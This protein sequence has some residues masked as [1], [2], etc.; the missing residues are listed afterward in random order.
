MADLMEIARGMGCDRVLLIT[1][2]RGSPGKLEM[3]EIDGGGFEAIPPLI[4]LKGI[5]LRREFGVEGRFI[6]SAIT[7]GPVKREGV[8]LARSLSSFLR[9]PMIEDRGAPRVAASLHIS[10]DRT[11]SL[12][13]AVT[14]P[15]KAKEVGPAFTIRHLIWGLGAEGHGGGSGESR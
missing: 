2:W 12:R 7:M 10:E 1:R 6:A 3:M 13:V 11:G 4:Y 14:S 9:M 8:E 5:K 15:P